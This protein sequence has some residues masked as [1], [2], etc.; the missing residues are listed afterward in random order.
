[1]FEIA[2]EMGVGVLSQVGA[3]TQPPFTSFD[4]G[5][6]KDVTKARRWILGR[7]E[8]ASQRTR[9]TC[10]PLVD[11]QEV[12]IVAQLRELV[13]VHLGR[14]DRVFSW[15][16]HQ[17]NDWVWKRPPT[18][19]GDYGHADPELTTARP[20][21]VLGRIERAAPSRLRYAGDFA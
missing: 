6:R 13:R 11:Q 19:G 3:R 10:S 1:V 15:P 4:R 9:L 12:A 17:D 2:R 21:G 20:I 18:S 7:I 8:S 14:A 5:E 16:A